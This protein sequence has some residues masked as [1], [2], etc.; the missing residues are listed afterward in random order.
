MRVL[1]VTFIKGSLFLA[2]MAEFKLTINNP[3]TGKG[4]KKDVSG[5]D[6]DALL[7]KDIG[8]K[9]SG[10]ALGFS[11]YEFEIMGGSDSSGFPMRHGIRGAV[12]QKIYT[13]KGVGFS[14]RNRWGKTEKGLR[15][16]TT[17]RGQKIAAETTQVNLKIVKEGSV[18]LFKAEAKPEEKQA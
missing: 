3:K 8:E 13:Y 12:R 11:G 2:F 17:V 6:A 16:K 7:S 1:V 14:G 10:D 9:V 15:V 5:K 4:Y 18:D